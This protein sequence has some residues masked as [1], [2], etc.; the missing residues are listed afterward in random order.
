MN[1]KEIFLDSGVRLL[2]IKTKKFK[3][4]E[5]ALNFECELNDDNITLY[6]LLMKLLTTKTGVHSSRE[7]F[8]K[9]LNDLYD[10]KVSSYKNGYGATLGFSLFVN[11]LNKDYV[12]NNENL[13]KKQ[14]E[15]LNEVLYKPL[16]KDE[17]FVNEYF[18]EIVSE[19]KQNLINLDNYKEY[20]VNKKVS[21]IVG[22][23]PILEGNVKCLKRVSNK[24]LYDSYLN[25]S[26]LCKSVMV[27]GDFE[28]EEVEKLVNEY[29]FFKEVRHS[30]NYF[31]KGKIEN[32]EDK[33]FSSSFN[34]SSIAVVYE[35]NVYIGEENYYPMLVFVEMFNY[36]L[37]K[38]VREEYNFCYSIYAHYLSSRGLCYLQ[39]NIEAK[40]YSKTLELIDKIVSD[41]AGEIDLSVLEICKK[42]IINNLKK[43]DDSQVKSLNREKMC[44][45][46]NLGSLDET[47]SRINNVKDEE[48]NE[49]SKLFKKKFSVILKEGK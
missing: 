29:L 17:E 45:L 28:F 27:I 15:V 13:L 36:Y 21:E 16:V 4:V 12:L 42:K 7:S 31:Y 8:K 24:D 26:S 35:C 47:I 38:I 30:Y 1:R 11:A 9:Y 39:S 44:F 19:Y 6:N 43:E 25:L 3:T 34:Q 5:V 33:E 20:V 48:I 10:M 41:L 2:M 18:K 32:T 37:F 49:V 23:F 14:F 40:N 46:Y 22:N